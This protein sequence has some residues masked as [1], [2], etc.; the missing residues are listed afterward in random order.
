[1][2]VGQLQEGA[3]AGRGSQQGGRAAALDGLRQGVET[4]P[5]REGGGSTGRGGEDHQAAESEGEGNGRG[6]DDDIVLRKADDVVAE[7]VGHGED[8]AMEMDAALGLA[9]GARGEGDQGG[10][11]GGGFDGGKTETCRQGLGGRL[12]AS[13]VHHPNQ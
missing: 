6:A 9:G 13:G 1:M 2:R 12:Q 4:G 10:V 8:V 11:V 5:G 3:I 7:G